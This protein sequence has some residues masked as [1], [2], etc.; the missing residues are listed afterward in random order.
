MS[1]GNSSKI[2]F[3]PLGNLTVKLLPKTHGLLRKN[4]NTQETVDLTSM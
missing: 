4:P 2:W 1:K 3:Q